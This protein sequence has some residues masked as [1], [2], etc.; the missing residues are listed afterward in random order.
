MGS[1]KS[2]SLC[3]FSLDDLC[4]KA[5]NEAKDLGKL[6]DGL[7]NEVTPQDEKAYKVL[8]LFTF[9]YLSHF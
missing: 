2:D 3:L 6:F 9:I 5:V 1:S 8:S 4:S 7:G